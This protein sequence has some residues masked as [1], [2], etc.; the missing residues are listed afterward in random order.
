MRIF[1][2]NNLKVCSESQQEICLQAQEI[3]VWLEAESP[4]QWYK[5]FDSFM[6]SQNL[7]EVSMIIVSNLKNWKMTYSLSWCYMLMICF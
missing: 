1:S 4:R 2:W 7:L 3:I 6:V 5:K